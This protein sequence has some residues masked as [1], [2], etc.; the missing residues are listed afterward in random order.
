[1]GGED[2]NFQPSLREAF[3]NAKKLMDRGSIELQ[4]DHFS[5]PNIK[6]IFERY[7]GPYAP[8]KHSKVKD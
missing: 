1:M 2:K 8:A 6:R 3:K 5:D 4:C 7:F